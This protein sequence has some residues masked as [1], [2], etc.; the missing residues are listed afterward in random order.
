M[1]KL[2]LKAFEIAKKRNWAQIYVACDI[3]ASLIMLYFL[4]LK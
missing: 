3:H 2:F 1:R 4:Y